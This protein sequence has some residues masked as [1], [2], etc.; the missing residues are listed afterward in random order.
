MESLSRYVSTSSQPIG[1]FLFTFSTSR[2]SDE[3]ARDFAEQ[4]AQPLIDRLY[5]QIAEG[6]SVL[7]TLERYVRQIEWFDQDRLHAE[8]LANTRQGENVYDRHLREFLFRE[9]FN[10][11]YSQQRSPSGLS[12]VLSDLESDDSLV[13]ELKVYDGGASGWCVRIRMPQVSVLRDV[14]HRCHSPVPSEQSVRNL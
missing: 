4:V 2:T 12:D 13:C 3:Q 10:M 14:R 9:G 7:Y 1:Q 5:E 6:S 8:F 11:P